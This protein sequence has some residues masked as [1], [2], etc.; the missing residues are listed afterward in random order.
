MYYRRQDILIDG[1]IVAKLF[2]FQNKKF[3]GIKF[4]TPEDLN[5]QLGL[6]SHNKNYVIKPHFHINKK[7]IKQMCEILIIFPKT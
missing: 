6:M 5:L 7:I 1:K 2:K 4:F 3:K